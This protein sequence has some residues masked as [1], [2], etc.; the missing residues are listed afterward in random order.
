[1]KCVRED[2]RDFGVVPTYSRMIEK[3]SISVCNELWG[4]LHFIAPP[5]PRTYG[6]HASPPTHLRFAK[7]GRHSQSP[8]GSRICRVA[9]ILPQLRSS[10]LRAAAAGRLGNARPSP[11]RGNRDEN[12]ETSATAPWGH[13][14]HDSGLHFRRQPARQ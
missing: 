1:M 9:L 11:L 12:I 10:V 2:D 5:T 6:G 7:R 13:V 3:S 8:H 14:S 4:A